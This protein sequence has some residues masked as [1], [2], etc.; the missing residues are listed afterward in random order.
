MAIV[1]FKEMD[2]QMDVGRVGRMVTCRGRTFGW[3]SRLATPRLQARLK[4]AA[5]S[6]VPAPHQRHDHEG[7]LNIQT[8]FL[9]CLLLA[10]ISSFLL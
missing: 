3:H 2:I 4:L 5:S 6:G 8:S 9:A 7:T 1:F 10:S